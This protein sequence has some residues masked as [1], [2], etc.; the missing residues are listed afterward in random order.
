[1]RRRELGS[2]SLQHPGT[3]DLLIK[4]QRPLC[5]ARGEGQDEQVHRDCRPI[6]TLHLFISSFNQFY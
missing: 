2:V 3:R 1:M 4:P 6:F 5:D